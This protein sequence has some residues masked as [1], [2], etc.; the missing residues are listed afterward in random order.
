MLNA[1]N[2][3]A[4]IGM[5]VFDY[6]VSW[7]P[8]CVGDQVI[9]PYTDSP[10][11]RLGLPPKTIVPRWFL[12][13]WTRK[14]ETALEI[15]EVMNRKG[16]GFEL[17]HESWGGQWVAAFGTNLADRMF[18]DS[19]VPAMAIAASALAVFGVEIPENQISV[20]GMRK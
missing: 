20:R 3:N 16:Y 8:H 6:R 12:P 2:I 7:A 9:H 15:V 17:K 1:L 13:D 4:T 5:R 11:Y 19:E 14:L 18:G 10:H